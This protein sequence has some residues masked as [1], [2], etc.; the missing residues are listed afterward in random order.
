MRETLFSAHINSDHGFVVTAIWF[1][2]HYMFRSAD[3]GGVFQHIQI[4][5]FLHDLIRGANNTKFDCSNGDY[6][7]S[8]N[9]HNIHFKLR[10]KDQMTCFS[11]WQTV[12][13]VCSLK[14]ATNTA[15]PKSLQINGTMVTNLTV[16]KHQKKYISNCS[17]NLGDSNFTLKSKKKGLDQDF[18]CTKCTDFWHD[19]KGFKNG[20]AFWTMTFFKTWKHFFATFFHH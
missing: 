4:N 13:M 14:K 10:T 16:Y 2:D 17:E 8:K 7:D 11:K 6:T 1:T 18:K 3:R 19:F 20:Y 12:L 9:S 5:V 15:C